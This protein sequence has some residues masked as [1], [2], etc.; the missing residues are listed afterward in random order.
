MGPGKTAEKQPE[1]Q[2]KHPKNSRKAVKTA[3]FRVF[4]LFFR[5]F[6]GCFTG[7]HSAPF[8]AV[9]QLFSMSGI[10]HPVGGR[11]DCKTIPF[12]ILEIPLLNGTPLEMTLLLPFLECPTFPEICRAQHPHRI[13]KT[14]SPFCQR[15]A[16]GAETQGRGK[17]T[18]IVR[19]RPGK[20]NQR[21]GQNETFMNFAH[22]CEFWCF[23]SLGKQA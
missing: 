8:S 23:F 17:H 1:K 21:K 6:F 19:S 11:G 15:K 3:V 16:K 10:W 22:F 14:N 18:M 7:T 12:E 4:R 13:A 2:P 5:L 20:P 9:F